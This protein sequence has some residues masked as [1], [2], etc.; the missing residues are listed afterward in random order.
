MFDDF[1]FLRPY[2]ETADLVAKKV[3][4]TG[5]VKI[6]REACY[7][8]ADLV[9]CREGAY[10]WWLCGWRRMRRLGTSFQECAGLLAGTA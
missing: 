1:A 7:V 2:K 3:R 10:N 9:G 6:C 5:S 8:T 4:K